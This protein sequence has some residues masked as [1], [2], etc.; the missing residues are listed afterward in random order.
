[1]GRAA[2]VTLIVGDAYRAN[3]QRYCER[4]WRAYASRHGLD[5]IVLE[6]PLDTSP[7]AQSR[8]PAWQKCLMLSQSFSAQ[9][10]QLIWLD[11]DIVINTH[12]APNICHFLPP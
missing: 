6:Q 4:N 8:S 9:Y 5:V 3:W 12:R 7:R 11:S 10:D 1:M 2:L